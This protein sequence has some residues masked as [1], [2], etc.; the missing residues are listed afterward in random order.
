MKYFYE[1][2]AGSRR[3]VAFENV[4]QINDAHVDAVISRYVCSLKYWANL[5]LPSVCTN[6]GQSLD[7]H[8][9]GHI[10]EIIPTYCVHYHSLFPLYHGEN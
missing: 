1:I 3:K 6:T 4:V 7:A 5:C 2:F 10:F 9:R 8:K